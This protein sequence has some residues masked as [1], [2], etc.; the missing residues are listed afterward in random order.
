MCVLI[1]RVGEQPLLAANRDEVYARPFSSPRRWFADTPFWAPRDEEEGGTWIGINQN[2]VMAAIT[3]RSRLEEVPGCASRGHLV[4]GA[5]AQAGLDSA[6]EWV[7]VEL[8]RA[9][10]NPCQLLLVQGP[11]ARIV[12]IAPTGTEWDNALPGFHVLSNLHDPDEIDFGLAPDAGW[13]EIR[14]ILADPSPRLPRDIAV[15]KRTEWR[16]TVASALI[17]PGRTFLFAPGPP[18]ETEYERVDYP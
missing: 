11:R 10:R 7:R 4:S 15:C 5:L 13:E 18:D 12:R 1:V 2:G 8:A 14:P 16:G 9:P 3:N 17:E 6:M